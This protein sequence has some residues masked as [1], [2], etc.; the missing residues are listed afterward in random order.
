MAI[1]VKAP[2]RGRATASRAVP[3]KRLGFSKSILYHAG[4][5][6]FACL[7][8]QDNRTLRPPFRVADVVN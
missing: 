1:A 7:D 4:R 3:P 2:K 6:V 8:S 5:V